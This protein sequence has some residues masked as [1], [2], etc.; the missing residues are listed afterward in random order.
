MSSAAR[1]AWLYEFDPSKPNEVREPARKVVPEYG[2]EEMD[3][4]FD[5]IFGADSKL[6]GRQHFWSEQLPEDGFDAESVEQV[7][8]GD[9]PDVALHF[10]QRGE[11]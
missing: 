5:S 7:R 2:E 3:D 4:W 8:H 6:G 11:T 1:L 9:W 10:C